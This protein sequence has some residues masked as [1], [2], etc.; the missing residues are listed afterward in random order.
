MCMFRLC[1]Q[2]NVMRALPLNAAGTAALAA[3]CAS[4][5]PAAS[6]TTDPGGLGLSPTTALGGEGSHVACRVTTQS[7]LSSYG[8]PPPLFVV[9][10]CCCDT[11]A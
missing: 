11:S 9:R 10:A 4:S 5:T 2:V 8:A 6:S 1:A 3:V 7:A